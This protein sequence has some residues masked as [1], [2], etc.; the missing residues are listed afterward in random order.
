MKLRKCRF[1]SA[2]LIT[3]VLIN[4]CVIPAGATGWSQRV[5]AETG[6]MTGTVRTE[7]IIG[8]S[9]RIVSFI[10]DGPANALEIQVTP[11][12]GT[13]Y[14]MKLRYRS[15]EVRNLMYQINGGP[16][17]RISGFNSGNW[18]SFAN[19]SVP[20]ILNPGQI[21]TIQFFAPDGECGPGLDYIDFS[22]SDLPAVDKTGYRLIFQDEFDAGTLDTSRWVPQYLSSWTKEPELAA[23]NYI[24]ENGLMRLQI[25]AETQ[26]WCPEYDGKTVV[27]GFTTGD[28]N[29]LHN[30][31][32]TNVV[33]NPVEMQATHLNQYGYYEIRAKGQAGSARHVAWWLLGFEDIPEESAEVDIFEILGNNS[34]KVPVNFH[35]WS[36]PDAPDGGGFS[37]TNSQMDFHDEFHIYGFNWIEGGGQGST[38]DKMEFY[39]DGVK[40]G[41]KNVN[42]D[43][44]MIQLFS[45]YEKRAGG[46]TGV[47]LPK[48][49]PNTF[50]IDY[51]RV[52]KPIP[53][54]QALPQDQLAIVEV[55]SQEVE[56][57]PS[58]HPA[59]YVSSV[60]GHEGAV[61]TEAHLPGVRSYVN[62]LYNDGV[63]TQEFV[64]W[65]ALSEEQY[66]QLQRGETVTLTGMTPN[67]PASTTGY[68]S[69]ILTLQPTQWDTNLNPEGLE[70]LFDGDPYS[71]ASCW[72]EIMEPLTKDGYISYRFGEM[73]TVNSIQFSTNYGSGQGIRSYTLS[74]WNT[75]T[76][77]WIDDGVEYNIPWTAAGNVETGE[78]VSVQLAEPVTTEAVRINITGANTRWENK[79]VMREI[80]FT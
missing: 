51:V 67:L 36:D 40:T 41:E 7:N 64:R 25:F 74:F 52:Y 59:Q 68:L 14:V 1:L 32:G 66:A 10:D 20:I 18:R 58:A 37:Y 50:D 42:I 38:P 78:T 63:K 6:V 43:Y 28:R 26:P 79:V 19:M 24:I 54:G 3:A 61:F 12:G 57:L 75:E 49:Y 72:T 71:T 16:T 13:D 17:N 33:R 70:N 47:W 5:E 53:D 44:P 46:W 8:N 80:M 39:V 22:E 27:S 65:P 29:A 9:G 4:L 2:V 21:N 23:P 35:A 55:E 73:K 30:W 45:L 62:V 48:P 60:S 56:V 15:G 11:Q 76:G 34:H 31:N 77:N 69:P